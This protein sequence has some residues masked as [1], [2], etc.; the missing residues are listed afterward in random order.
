[1]EKLDA[2]TRLLGE[3]PIPVVDGK[4]SSAYYQLADA[5]ASALDS[6][7]DKL[8]SRFVQYIWTEWDASTESEVIS[9]FARLFGVPLFSTD[10]NVVKVLFPASVAIVSGDGSLK[11]IG[12]ALTLLVDGGLIDSFTVVGWGTAA[13]RIDVDVSRLSETMTAFFDWA[14]PRIVAAGVS[15]NVVEH[16]SS[17]DFAFGGAWEDGPLSRFDAMAR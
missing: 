16:D 4:E 5:I 13:V 10:I 12:H 14:A 7:D 17:S 1:M 3:L 8:W 15:C 11:A 9:G 6:V 2:Q